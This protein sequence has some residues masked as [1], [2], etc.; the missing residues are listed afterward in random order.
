MSASSPLP[1]VH[2][3]DAGLP[4]PVTSHKSGGRDQW[5]A[6]L[7]A[8][9]D[10]PVQAT[11]DALGEVLDPEIP[12]SLPELGLIYGVEFDD[13]VARISLTFTATACPC[14]EFIHEDITD[15]LESERWIDSVELVEV[16]DPPWTSEKITTE[17]REKLRRLG[18]S[19]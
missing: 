7:E 14:M 17:G 18:V 8:A 12:I 11:W 15:R 13:G 6:P 1:I 16:W 9:P 19:A 3:I 4:Q 2:R 5:S 10:D